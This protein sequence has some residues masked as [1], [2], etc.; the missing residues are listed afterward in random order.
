MSDKI[1]YDKDLVKAAH[2]HFSQSKVVLFLLIHL[3]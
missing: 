3:K 1:A 2:F